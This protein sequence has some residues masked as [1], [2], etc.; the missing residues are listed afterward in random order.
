VLGF[1]NPL[2]SAVQVVAV[3]HGRVPAHDEDSVGEPVLVDCGRRA[4][5]TAVAGI[6]DG[7]VDHP[8]LAEGLDLL[9][10][11]VQCS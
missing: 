3:D 1:R 11:A 7:L 9:E 5:D 10:V 2:A 8:A 4:H 6:V